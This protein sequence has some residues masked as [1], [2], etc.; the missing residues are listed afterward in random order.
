MCGV[1]VCVCMCVCVCVGV[2]VCMLV[3]VHVRCVGVSLIATES[4]IIKFHQSV[5]AATISISK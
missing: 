5:I 1:Q 2:C 4:I 3:C